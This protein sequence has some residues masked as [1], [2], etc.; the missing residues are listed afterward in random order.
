MTIVIGSDHAGYVLKEF[1]KTKLG[2]EGYRVVDYGTDSEEPVDYP[3]VAEKVALAVKSSEESLGIVVCGTGIGMSIAANKIPGIR[4]AVCHSRFTARMAREHNW[5]NVIAV[6]ARVLEPNE[7]WEVVKEF[8]S[9][10]FQGGRHSRRI[11]KI[12]ALETKYMSPKYR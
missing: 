3:D 5:V 6:G 4:A 2:G 12:T 8:L 10:S 7:A 9:A 1:L 11:E